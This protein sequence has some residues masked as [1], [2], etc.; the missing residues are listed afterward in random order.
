MLGGVG[1]SAAQRGL[2]DTGD[3]AWVRC[4]NGTGASLAAGVP[5]YLNY[6]SSLNP[7]AIALVDDAKYHTIGVVD[8]GM[9]SSLSSTAPAGAIAS[10]EW[11]WVKTRGRVTI[12][13]ASADY[14]ATHALKLHNGA[15]ASTAAVPDGSSPEFAVVLTTVV[16]S[17]SVDSYLFGR[18]TILSTT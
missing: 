6:S 13:V 5:V 18:D 17:T 14:T 11:G 15:V 3:D 12:T 16:A 8:G 2:N 10:A 9:A 7:R 1:A 4:Y